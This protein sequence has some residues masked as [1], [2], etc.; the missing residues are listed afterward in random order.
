[1]IVD[2]I[3]LWAF[4]V[5]TMAIILISVEAGF[6]FA[7]RTARRSP[8]EKESPAAAVGGAVLALVAFIL[9][10]TF[11][12]ASAR[13]DARKQ[14]V[15]DDAEAVRSAWLQADFLGEPDRHEFRQLLAG[16]LD[17]RLAVAE[18]RDLALLSQ[19]EAESVAIHG[20]L[21]AY[22]VANGRKDSSDISAMFAESVNT[23]INVNARRVAVA[24][25]GRIAVGIWIVLYVISVLGMVATGYQM[26]VAGPQRSRTG[27][28]LAAS[29]A[30]V[31]TLI[32]GLDRPF[33][34]FAPVTQKPL[35]DVRSYM[36]QPSDQPATAATRP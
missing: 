9:A 28:L 10:F 13:F 35:R 21:W 31:M 26:G 25:E 23:V 14:L 4:F 2:A 1:M 11:G 33:S 30:L 6:M 18:S 29:F 17:V 36:E 5:G 7:R 20:R 8:D 19:A 15:R 24:W 3:P 27:V 12:I 32:A 22:A 16:Y 34:P